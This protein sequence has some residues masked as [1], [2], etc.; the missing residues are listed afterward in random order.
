LDM[1]VANK[2]EKYN[3]N[4]ETEIAQ[5]DNECRCRDEEFYKNHII[6]KESGSSQ[7]TD[8]ENEIFTLYLNGVPCEEIAVRFNVETEVISG[9]LKII[10]AKFSIHE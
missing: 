7:L 4:W 1:V 6:I 2:R 10:C 8:E 3:K 9:L 5:Y